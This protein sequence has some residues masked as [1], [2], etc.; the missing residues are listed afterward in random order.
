MI[1]LALPMVLK[2]ESCM[3]EAKGE[4]QVRSG[5]E[6]SV[7]VRRRQVVMTLHF[8]SPIVIH[9]QDVAAASSS[10]EVPQVKDLC[11]SQMFRCLRLKGNV[12]RG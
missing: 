2:T 6:P 1:I 7:N 12:R 9:S 11:L 3:H 4:M 5:L 10:C 8:N